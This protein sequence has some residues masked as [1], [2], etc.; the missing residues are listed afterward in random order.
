MEVASSST[1]PRVRLGQPDQ[2]RDR[3]QERVLRASAPVRRI[4]LSDGLEEHPT[5]AVRSLASRQ[6]DVRRERPQLPHSGRGDPVH[7]ARMGRAHDP[8]LELLELVGADQCPVLGEQYRQ[9][10]TNPTPLGQCI[11]QINGLPYTNPYG[12]LGT[13]APFSP[14]VEFNVRARYDWELD[15]YKALGE[16]RRQPHWLDEQRA[17]EFP[18][19]R[20]SLAESRRPRRCCVMRS[21]D[22][23]PMMRPSA[24]PRTHGRRSSPAAIWATSTDRRTYP[25]GSSSRR[26]FRCG[27]AYSPSRSD[28]SSDRTAMSHGARP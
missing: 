27:R 25:P 19:R 13:R 15:K 8:G 24:L 2:Q 1:N 20:L 10:P 7:R 12:Q 4:H 28:T 18:E 3:L 11:T 17:G 16:R 22:T 9:R 14:A 5:A 6:H 21:R 23:R 26:R